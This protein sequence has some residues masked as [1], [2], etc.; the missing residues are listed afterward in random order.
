[1]EGRDVQDLETLFAQVEDPRVERTRAASFT[2][3]HHPGDLWRDLRSR[4]MG[5]DRGIWEGQR[6]VV[7]GPARL[8][9][10]YPVA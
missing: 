7:Y 3:Y 5:R 9:Q 10:W 8:G 1:M 4:G 2:R 6:N